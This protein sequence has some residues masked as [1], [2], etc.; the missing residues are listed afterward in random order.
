MGADLN[1]A[2]WALIPELGRRGVEV[3]PVAAHGEWCMQANPWKLELMG[4]WVAGPMPKLGTCLGADQATVTDF[5]GL[6]LHA[7]HMATAVNTVEDWPGRP[8]RLVQLL[9]FADK[10]NR[11]SSGLQNSTLLYQ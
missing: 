3:R 6:D 8:H 11:C 1:M 7:H 10:E 2:L 9:F 5:F 4:I